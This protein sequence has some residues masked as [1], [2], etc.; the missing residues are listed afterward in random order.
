[1]VVQIRW[2]QLAIMPE[3][4]NAVEKNRIP[5]SQLKKRVNMTCQQKIQYGQIPTSSSMLDK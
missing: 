2:E 3:M 5:R 4:P 1:M